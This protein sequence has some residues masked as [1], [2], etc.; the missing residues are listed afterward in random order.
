MKDMVPKGTGNSRFLRSSIAADIT[1]E[2]L[3]AL[4]RSGKFPVDFAGLNSAGIQVQGS[5]YNKGNV[6]PDSVCSALGIVTTS[7]PKDA[8]LKLKSTINSEKSDILSRFVVGTYTGT[9]EFVF[10]QGYQNPSQSINLGKS[11]SFVIIWV[12]GVVVR[13][14]AVGS[15]GYIGTCFGF[16]YKNGVSSDGITISSSGFTVSCTSTDL[17]NQGIGTV[18]NEKNTKYSY[19]AYF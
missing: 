15:G 10:G 12:N 8:F 17:Y 3:V 2:E 9:S 19:F 14:V 7:E 1:H 16:A 4:L 13:F 5:A 18:L 6:L 11:P